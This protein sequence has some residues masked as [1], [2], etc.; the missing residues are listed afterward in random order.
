MKSLKNN[1]RRN[2]SLT[3]WYS[4][5]KSLFG[6]INRKVDPNISIEASQIIIDRLI[7]KNLEIRT[8]VLRIFSSIIREI[9]KK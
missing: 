1:L 7:S 4:Q 2:S 9:K 5:G 8:I 6:K 3:D